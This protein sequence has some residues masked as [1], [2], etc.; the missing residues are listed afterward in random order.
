MSN[1]RQCSGQAPLKGAVRVAEGRGVYGIERRYI[2]N[3]NL[4]MIDFHHAEDSILTIAV[5]LAD[6]D[7]EMQ[8]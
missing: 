7:N 6:F 8:R 2:F 4:K 5:K 1:F 3:L